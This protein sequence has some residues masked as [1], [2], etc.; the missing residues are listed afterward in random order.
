MKRL[1]FKIDNSSEIPLY[2]Q[3]RNEIEQL[4]GSAKLQPGN[5]LPSIN[6]VAGELKLASGTVIRAYEELKELGII[7]SKQ[8]KGYF[9]SDADIVL[10]TRIFLLFDRIAAFKE[11]L[12][13]S[14]RNEFDEKTEIQVF[15]HHYDIKRF[16]KLIR[17]NFGKFS[18]YVL[19]PHLNENVQKCISQLPEKKVILIDNLPDNLKSNI[20]A[21][22][23][24]F[25]GDINRALKQKIN[26]I[27]NYGAVNLSLS[28]NKFQFVPKG[29]RK[30]FVDFCNEF[31]INHKI[32]QSISKANL[33]ENE[34]YII[35]DDGE[36]LNTL[37]LIQSKGWKLKENIGIISFDET[38]MKQLLAGGISVLSTDFEQ[39]GKT[40]ADLVKG[41]IAGQIANPFYFIDRNS[42]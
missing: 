33:T 35:F 3:I 1:N 7:T 4:I 27:K 36:L 9:I 2:K 16:E 19:M 28:L 21:V 20:K 40:A 22:Y 14:F 12:Y 6:R 13:E 15:F 39:M 26:Q 24:D 8:G 38:P 18:H 31:Q 17:E 37:K 42:F 32:I 11:I 34:L 23:Q 25:Y 41:K 5:Q 10:Q 30:G 29:I